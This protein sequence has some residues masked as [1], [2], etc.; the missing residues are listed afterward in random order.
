MNLVLTPSVAAYFIVAVDWK[1]VGISLY[2][3][4]L[5]TAYRLHLFE[6]CKDWPRLAQVALFTG[7]LFIGLGFFCGIAVV[8][9]WAILPAC[10][11]TAVNIAGGVAL[12]RAY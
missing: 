9:Y 4:L 12:R 3:A 5:A 6:H 10:V 8:G 2:L 7:P 11:C 1:V